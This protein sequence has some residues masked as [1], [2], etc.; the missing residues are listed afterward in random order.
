[1][2]INNKAEQ[3]KSVNN[4][5]KNTKSKLTTL[6]KMKESFVNGKPK[7]PKNSNIK[8]VGNLFVVEFKNKLTS[9]I[10]LISSNMVI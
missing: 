6:T 7:F 5:I 9:C 4:K 1:M 10:M 3:I 8:N 2:Y